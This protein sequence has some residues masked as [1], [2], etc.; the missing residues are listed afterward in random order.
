[1]TG[2]LSVNNPTPQ[3]PV[4]QGRHYLPLIYPSHIGRDVG[5]TIPLGNHQPCCKKTDAQSLTVYSV[6]L[7]N[8]RVGE[9]I[10]CDSQQYLDSTVVK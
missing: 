9:S 4:Q 2:T 8:A 1:M 5:Q 3:G 7:I 10:N 6:N